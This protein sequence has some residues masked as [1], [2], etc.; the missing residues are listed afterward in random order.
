ML[1]TLNTSVALLLTLFLLKSI[2]LVSCSD[3]VVK[4]LKLYVDGSEFFIKAMCY[5]PSPLGQPVSVSDGSGGGFCSPKV[6]PFGS[7][8]T[9]C[10]DSDY[11]DG[12]PNAADQPSP[13]GGGWFQPVWERDFPL[14]KELGANTIRIYN[15]NPTTK[16]ASIYYP[17]AVRLPLGKDHIP[18]MNLASS[19]GFQVIFP[20]ISDY[21]IL[22]TYDAATFKRLLRWQIDEV[23]N[24]PALLMWAFGNELPLNGNPDLVNLMNMY[25]TYIKQ[26]TLTKWGKNILITVAVVDLPE[27]YNTLAATLDVDIFTTNAGYRG[28]TFS[29]L[30]TGNSIFQG[31]Y[32]LSCRYNKPVF[33]GELGWHTI[34]NSISYTNPDWFNQIWKDLVGHI[35]QGCVGGAFFE[36]SD[37][38]LKPTEQQ[39]MGLVTPSVNS[40]GGMP[41]TQQYVWNADIVTRKDIIF[42]AVKG[43]SYQGVPY[44]MNASPF[45]L[46]GRSQ[47]TL[48]TSNPICSSSFP[49]FVDCP[50]GNT[51]SYH[52]MCDRQTG[53]CTCTSGWGGDDCSQ[54]LCS[55][56]CSGNG[57]CDGSVSP[58]VCNCNTGW[59]GVSCSVVVSSST[60]SQN[61][62]NLN[63][64]CDSTG[65]CK[66]YQ[67]WLGHNCAIPDTSYPSV[68]STTTTTTTTTAVS[69]STTGSQDSSTSA[70]TTTPAITSAS[71]STTTPA[72]T[73]SSTSET[74]SSTSTSASDTTGTSA[75][76]TST[77]SSSSTSST[78]IPTT[79]QRSSAQPTTSA[80]TLTIVL[81]LICYLL[82]L[83]PTFA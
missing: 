19:Y 73:S 1:P 11:F 74:A 48:T 75:S 9:T 22:T 55:S 38:Q 77:S 58:P 26:Y 28:F 68:S 36:Y 78:V 10:Y 23:G 40:S 69:T 59:T 18:F 71:A 7:T 50:G 62:V 30:W 31:W 15:T 32:A 27:S 64:Q 61:C 5:N 13:P 3:V 63:G 60:C 34:N 43:G 37:E 53:N 76:S 49:S 54:A 56:A 20:L 14:M 35:D 70:S 41:S 8:L 57:V 83:T 39:T 16:Q 81:L 17:Q 45:D 66:C 51:C 80:T 44:N 52:G 67:G 46:I 2:C 24:H 21:T 82:I 4:N 65:V 79:A 33:I 42:A 6:S 72:T 29:D 25:I 12:G 47:T